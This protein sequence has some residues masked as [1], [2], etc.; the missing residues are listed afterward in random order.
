MPHQSVDLPLGPDIGAPADLEPL[1]A[2]VEARL[3]DLAQSMRERDI[4]A[5]ETQSNA[6]HRALAQAVESFVKAAQRSA[7]PEPLRL[8]LARASGQL[9][10]QREALSR[11]TAALDRAIDVLMPGATPAGKVYLANGLTEPLLYTGGLNA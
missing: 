11:A 10:R 4:D 6:L 5:I 7:L 1:V 3:A 9:A 8:R 2:E